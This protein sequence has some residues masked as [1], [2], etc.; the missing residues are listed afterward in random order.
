MNSQELCTDIRS[1]CRQHADPAIVEKYARYFKEGYD[2]W[3]LPTDLFRAKVKELLASKT[4]TM[5]T[6]IE[7]SYDLI[8]SEK[9]EE[10]GLAMQLLKGFSKQFTKDTFK[11][12]EQWDP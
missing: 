10:P 8:A 4:L 12:I 5:E 7:A 2:A 3:G 11:V 6:V 9:Y 1:F